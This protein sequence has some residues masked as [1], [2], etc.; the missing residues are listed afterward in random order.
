MLL[1]CRL[2]VSEQKLELNFSLTVS[3]NGKLTPLCHKWKDFCLLLAQ[4][5]VWLIVIGRE[6]FSK[7]DMVFHFR[8]HD[9]FFEKPMRVIAAKQNSCP[10]L[11]LE[12]KIQ[13]VGAGLAFFTVV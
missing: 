1:H 8:S 4:V 13:N 5:R 2:K 9:S 6:L 3:T 10:F 7:N 11:I 12:R